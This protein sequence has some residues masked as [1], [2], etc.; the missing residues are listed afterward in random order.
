MTDRKARATAKG[1][2]SQDAGAD[3]F[4]EMIDRKRKDNGDLQL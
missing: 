3:S 2:S 1:G 4:L